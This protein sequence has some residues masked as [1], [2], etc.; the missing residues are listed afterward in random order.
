MSEDKAKPE[1]GTWT[2][3]K[4]RGEQ[5]TNSWQAFLQKTPPSVLKEHLARHHRGMK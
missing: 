3:R 1:G 2:G 4:R 5:D